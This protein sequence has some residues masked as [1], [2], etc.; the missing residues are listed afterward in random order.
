MSLAARVPFFQPTINS[1]HGLTSF[2]FYLWP[3]PTALTDVL[4]RL[5]AS[6]LPRCRRFSRTAPLDTLNAAGEMVPSR[7]AL[8]HFHRTI[9]QR[10]RFQYFVKRE[11]QKCHSFVWHSKKLLQNCVG[12]WFHKRLN[13]VDVFSFWRVTKNACKLVTDSK[14]KRPK[15]R[16][17]PQ[18]CAFFKFPVNGWISA[19][20]FLQ[21][22]MTISCVL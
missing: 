13:G 11:W 21:L 15:Q 6:T 19:V 3:V 10:A 17:I 8:L 14:K 1:L 4:W 12:L 18:I 2:P 16:F 5:S 7:M 9:T 22:L 20:Y